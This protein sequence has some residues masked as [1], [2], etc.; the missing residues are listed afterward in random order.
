MDITIKFDV[1]TNKYILKIDN[2]T[3][4]LSIQEL[5]ELEQKI[6]DI[7]KQTP[8]LFNQKDK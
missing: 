6:T 3:I 8:T 7:I 5:Q 1:E 2:K 4:S